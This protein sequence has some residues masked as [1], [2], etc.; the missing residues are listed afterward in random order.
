MRSLKEIL[1]GAAAAELGEVW[2]KGTSVRRTIGEP[3][4]GRVAFV[5]DGWIYW[6]ATDRRFH[7]SR[8]DTLRRIA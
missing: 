4:E 2:P 8:P 5:D 7:A 6:V 1:R 3:L